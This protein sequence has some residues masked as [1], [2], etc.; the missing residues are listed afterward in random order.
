[1]YW[2]KGGRNNFCKPVVLKYTS[3]GSGTHRLMSL[4]EMLLILCPKK[5]RN[6]FIITVYF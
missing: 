6:N 2:E 4:K 5:S 1:M 3:Y